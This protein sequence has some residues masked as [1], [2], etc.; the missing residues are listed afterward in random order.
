[1][2]KNTQG[3]QIISVPANVYGSV[4]DHCQ[5]AIFAYFSLFRNIHLSHPGKTCK[6]VWLFLNLDPCTA[7]LDTGKERIRN[8]DAGLYTYILF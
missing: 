7:L 4:D 1:M 5:G 2:H 8:C 3:D 6:A